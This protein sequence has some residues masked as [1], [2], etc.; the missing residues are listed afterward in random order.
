MKSRSTVKTCFHKYSD[1]LFYLAWQDAF[2]E[3]GIF[4]KCHQNMAERS[5]LYVGLLMLTRKATLEAVSLSTCRS[6]LVG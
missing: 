5:I 2:S 6:Q 1:F 3:G 4:Q